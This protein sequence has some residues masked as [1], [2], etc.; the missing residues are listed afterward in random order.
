MGRSGACRKFCR[1][2]IK[3]RKGFAQKLKQNVESQDLNS[4]F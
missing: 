2:K 1:T 3:L 4:K